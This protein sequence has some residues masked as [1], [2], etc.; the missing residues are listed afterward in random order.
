MLATA[1]AAA[2]TEASRKAWQL[3]CRRERANDTFWTDSKY[4]EV[5]SY[6][7]APKTQGKTTRQPGNK[8][9]LWGL[10]FDVDTNIIQMSQTSATPLTA[11]ASNS[12]PLANSCARCVAHPIPVVMDWD[13]CAARQRGIQDLYTKQPLSSQLLP[14][15]RSSC[16]HACHP[17][18][19][20][21]T[22]SACERVHQ[23]LGS[24][25]TL[26]FQP[27]KQWTKGWQPQQ[28]A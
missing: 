5:S 14:P 17:I 3:N 7:R 2:K 11:G 9:A 8:M 26:L 15:S 28:P 24:A 21:G 19:G 25:G 1:A 16:W 12:T 22:I 23:L 6:N 27:S 18:H 20:C 10:M 13:A 4:T